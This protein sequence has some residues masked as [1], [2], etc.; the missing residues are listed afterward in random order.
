M[1]QRGVARGGVDEGAG[2]LLRAQVGNEPQRMGVVCLDP[3]Q[4]LRAR[5]DHRALGRENLRECFLLLAIMMMM[6]IY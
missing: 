3:R 4:L 1:Q 6:M 5:V 2:Q